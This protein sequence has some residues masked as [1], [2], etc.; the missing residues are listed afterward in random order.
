MFIKTVNLMRNFFDVIVD[1]SLDLQN[2]NNVITIQFL[3]ILNHYRTI[4]YVFAVQCKFY[5]KLIFNTAV[6]EPL[7]VH[8]NCIYT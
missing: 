3:R 7:Q 5:E 6:I 1:I 8:L 2:K 4:Y